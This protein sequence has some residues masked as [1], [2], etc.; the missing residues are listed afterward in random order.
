MIEG[1]FASTYL[2]DEL[3]VYSYY[4]ICEFKA[5]LHL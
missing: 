5:D 1:M 2:Y 4:Y 3:A